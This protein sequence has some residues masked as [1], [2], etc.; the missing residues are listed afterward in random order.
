MPRTR[1]RR[2][3]ALR[4]ALAA[5]VP[6]V[7]LAPSAAHAAAPA[8]QATGPA[9]TWATAQPLTGG[10]AYTPAI[11]EGGFSAFAPISDNEYWTISDRGPNGQPTVT[12]PGS[13]KTE[14]RR[15][16]LTPG[17]TPTIYRIRVES[18]NSLTVLKRIPLKL[19][20]GAVDPAQAWL[21][22]HEDSSKGIIAGPLNQITGLP[23]IVTKAQGQDSGLPADQA[24]YDRKNARD[25]VPY[26]A[27]GTTTLPSD[28]YGLD[29]EAI[30]VDPR[31]GSF[32]LGDEY[33][34]TLQHV[35]ADGTLLGRIVP[36]GVNVKQDSGTGADPAKFS[37]AD[38]AVVP[39][40]GV[41]P[42]AFAFRKQ[43]RGM[44]GATLSKDG[45]TLFGLMQ[46][47][48][49]GPA[50]GTT[51]TTGKGDE[52]TLRLVRFDVTDPSAP[53]LTGEFAYRLDKFVAG[54]GITKQSDVSNSDIAAIDATHLIVDEHDNVTSAP[55]KGQKKIYSIDLAGATNLADSTVENGES[56][57][58]EATNAAG[59]DAERD[60]GVTAVTPVTKTVLLDLTAAGYDHDKP[61]GIG[62]FPNGDLAIQ[63]DNDFGFDQAD[64]PG[65]GPTTSPFKV[66]ASGKTTQLW[67]FTQPPVFTTDPS[68]TGDA[69]VGSTLTCTDGVSKYGTS[70]TRQW[71]R[72][73]RA[74]P[75]A[76]GTTYAV[77]A[78]DVGRPLLCRVTT[79][80]SAG[81]ATADSDTVV[82]VQAGQTGATGP[83]GATG[84]G[85]ATG[86]KGAAGTAGAQGPKGDA[87][88]PGAKGDTG[89]RGP[90]GSTG[91]R[92]PAG[93]VKVSCKVTSRGRRVTC[94][95]TGS[96][97][98]A[99]TRIRL[100][101]AG[102]TVATA[103]LSHGKVVLRPRAAVRRG[104]YVVATSSSRVAFRVR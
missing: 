45:K 6:A 101:R 12:I 15:T 102:K 48:L 91:K 99:G 21:K 82:P 2:R 7:L 1:S 57:T 79:T 53:K 44:E 10:D 47:S 20:S 69:V 56:P 98:K 76:T 90:K 64:E 22:A 88:A 54:D 68:I 42:R 50:A 25:E 87:G 5:A 72:G 26:A 60:A 80:G 58:L 46:S 34:P 18:D 63:N 97:A 77:T 9:A 19:K 43:N 103:R 70:V 33:R 93:R 62:F 94:R 37:G 75:G 71:L 13:T 59:T 30:A 84:P 73:G 81:S 86:P 32:W 3:S 36:G 89:A 66:T 29:T 17:F 39:T 11:V 92:G 74:V 41:L 16:F 27:D 35:A 23:Q 83:V 65:T 28:P 85:G 104:R 61:E 95:I 31:D 67:R 38:D 51:S 4:V 14:K 55:G 100:T 96:A 49:E 52:R 40:Y 24:P 8:F 78:A